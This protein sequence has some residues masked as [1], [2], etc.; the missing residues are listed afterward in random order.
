MHAIYNLEVS[1]R[2]SFPKWSC[3]E[4]LSCGSGIHPPS[5]FLSALTDQVAI[6]FRFSLAVN[7]LFA[8]VYPTTPVACNNL[9]E[10]RVIQ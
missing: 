10:A 3:A 7:V 5:F 6:I 4:W 2:P 9:H 8:E 1:L